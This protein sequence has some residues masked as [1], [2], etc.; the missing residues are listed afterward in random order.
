[1]IIII[2]IITLHILFLKCAKSVLKIGKFIVCLQKLS[3]SPSVRGRGYD[4]F[5]LDRVFLTKEP[6]SV[7]IRR[8]VDF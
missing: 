2:F 6:N 8:G 5:I 4:I 1:M 7:K 3:V